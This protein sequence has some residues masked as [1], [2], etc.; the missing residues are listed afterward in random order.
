MS[1]FSKSGLSKSSIISNLKLLSQPYTC[2]IKEQARE[3]TVLA[4]CPTIPCSWRSGTRGN[5]ES[6]GWVRTI[7][8]DAFSKPVVDAQLTF[9]RPI[10]LAVS[11][12][13]T[14]Y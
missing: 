5:V 6:L 13:V 10:I 12:L 8:T 2:L 1:I 11:I 14:P 9:E 7:R 3:G 4:D